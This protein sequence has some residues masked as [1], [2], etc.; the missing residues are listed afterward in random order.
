GAPAA[1]AC[2]DYSNNSKTDWFLPSKDELNELYVNRDYVGN[3]I[4]DNKWYWSS[5]QYD[6]EYPWVQN[7]TDG[8]NGTQFNKFVKYSPTP[9]RAVRA[10]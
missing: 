2:N 1:K 8:Q 10:F 3:L 7:F 6:S 5:S 9:V 4:G